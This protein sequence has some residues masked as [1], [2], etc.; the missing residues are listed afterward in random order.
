MAII[1]RNIGGDLL[2]V[3]E[4]EVRINDRRITTFKHDRQDG[5]G[6]CLELASKAAI[7][8]SWLDAAKAL[9]TLNADFNGTSF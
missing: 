5:L 1:I 2:G 9:E 7:Q 6:K 3:C 4:Y 8:Q